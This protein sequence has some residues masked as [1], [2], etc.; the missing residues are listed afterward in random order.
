MLH[1]RDHESGAPAQVK[2]QYA[3]LLTQGI[4]DSNMMQFLGIIE[5]RAG[6]ILS[7]VRMRRTSGVQDVAPSREV[8]QAPQRHEIDIL[9][10][11]S[12]RDPMEE[13]DDEA[14][15][16]RPLTRSEL[17]VFAAKSTSNVRSMAKERSMASKGMVT[18]PDRLALRKK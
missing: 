1:L 17:K 10:P 2:A 16:D 18:A 7:V 4:T 9:P 12:T 14:D 6:D 8:H 11:S 3:E 5:K 13:D 15:V